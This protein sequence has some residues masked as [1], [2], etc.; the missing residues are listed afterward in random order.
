[1]MA[2]ETW[3]DPGESHHLIPLLGKRKSEKRHIHLFHRCFLSAF[4]GPGFVL[5]G[6]RNSEKERPGP[7]FTEVSVQSGSQML[8]KSSHIYADDHKQ[9]QMS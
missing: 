7:A 3:K 6:G 8:A 5:H 9:R 1:M 4:Y 2:Q